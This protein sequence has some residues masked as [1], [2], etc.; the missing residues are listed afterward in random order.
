MRGSVCVLLCLSLGG[1]G[2]SAVGAEIQAYAGTVAGAAFGGGGFACATSGP[3][4]GNGWFAG[5]ALPTEGFAGCNLAGGIE[6]KTAAAGSLSASQSVVGPTAP[7]QFIGSAD[8]LASFGTLGVAATG[9][10]EGPTSSFTYGS[11]AAFARFQDELTIT[12]PGVANGTLGA[13]NFSFLLDGTMTN[14]HVA[15]YTQQADARL[16]VRVNGLFIWDAFRA[17]MINDTI[18][19]VRG[20]SVGLPGGFTLGLGSVSGSAEI[21]T[22][23]FFGFVWGTPFTLE[24]AL[25]N[26]LNPCCYGATQTVDFL[27][28]ARLSG[29]QVY[30][31]SGAVPDFNVASGSGTAYSAAGI[32]PV[33]LPAAVWLTASGFVALGG[34]QR[35][36]QNRAR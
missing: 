33:P 17:T 4:I 27:N 22:T 9:S 2:G 1:A 32:G 12:S 7:G 26:S 28:S 14:S 19:Y 36:I 23:A 24:V 16:G 3:T 8:A 18:P 5:I 15:P 34:W 20:G 31:A 11:A 25:M 35:R 21:T 10:K 30:T 29:I 6:N 13:I